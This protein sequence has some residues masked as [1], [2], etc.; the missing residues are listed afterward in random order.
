MSCRLPSRHFPLNTHIN[1]RIVIISGGREELS[2]RGHGVLKVSYTLILVTV[3][4]MYI[5]VK[6]I[7]RNMKKNAL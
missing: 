3:T 7:E 2:D 1:V 4:W 6:T 5:Y